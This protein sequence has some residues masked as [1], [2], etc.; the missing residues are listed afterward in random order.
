MIIIDFV[1]ENSHLV[2]SAPR[3]PIGDY[4]DIIDLVGA[5][6]FTV[7]S[8]Q[9]YDQTGICVPLALIEILNSLSNIIGRHTDSQISVIME[10]VAFLHINGEMVDIYRTRKMNESA[11]S[12]TTL[13]EWIDIRALLISR[14]QEHYSGIWDAIIPRIM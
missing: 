5:L 7:N 13:D 12:T 1:I 9:I 11:I 2:G 8:H 10:E 4:S 6:T 14:L 3:D